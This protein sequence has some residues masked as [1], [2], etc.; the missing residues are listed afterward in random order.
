MIAS[1][2]HV[3]KT[4]YNSQY[5]DLGSIGVSD[6][7]TTPI[8]AFQL[9]FLAMDNDPQIVTKA[10][11]NYEINGRKYVL[12]VF[13]GQP[14]AKDIKAQYAE[15]GYEFVRT[16]PI[17][18]YEIPS[19]VRGETLEV[20]KIETK[21]QLDKANMALYL[22]NESIPAVTLNDPYI[23]NFYAEWNGRIAG[24][25]QLVTV[26][27][28]AGYINQLY[29][30]TDFRKQQV[31]TSLMART[32]IECTQHGIQRMA[33]V[34]SDMALG[35]YRRLGYRPM[36]YFTALRLKEPPPPSQAPTIP[37]QF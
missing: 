33:L 23:Q 24:W 30:L 20:T 1:Y 3:Y 37:F 6:Y 31:G 8:T 28:G 36:A 12:D 10:I 27:P 29:T 34:S 35:L 25:V 7:G 13:H 11:E 16:G 14:S 5:F 26:Y 21:D 18:G 17:L 9:E 32:H 2:N 4:V 15:H 19:P 22:E